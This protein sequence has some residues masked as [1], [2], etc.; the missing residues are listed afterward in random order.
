MNGY[1]AYL[2]YVAL[3]THFTKSEYDF[4][5]NKGQ[6]NASYDS[7]SARNDKYFFEKLAELYPTRERC[8][9]FILCNLL[10]D[11]NFYVGDF[12]SRYH[13]KNYQEWLGR[14]TSLVYIFEQ[15]LRKMKDDID[16][17]DETFRNIFRIETGKSTSR[18]VEMTLEGVVSLE[19]YILVDNILGLTEYY[20]G[21]VSDPLYE[22][23]AF[24]VR[25]YSPFIQLDRA[26]FSQ[27]FESFI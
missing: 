11:K 7:F 8:L 24:K 13:E 15:D 3:K 6:I 9:G 5:K 4:F 16:K 23:F 18:F 26:K 19:T 21:K 1:K 22:D 25:K 2:L 27:I 12:R 10:I 17:I 14:I 20:D